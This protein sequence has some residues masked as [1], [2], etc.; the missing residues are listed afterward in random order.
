MYTSL[1]FYNKTIK[2]IFFLVLFII[3]SCEY[4]I[5]ISYHINEKYS[6]IVD[7][8]K[9]EYSKKD[10]ITNEHFPDI[11]QKEIYNDIEKQNIENKSYNNE[12]NIEQGEKPCR[13]FKETRSILYNQTVSNVSFSPNGEL[14]A[15]LING[16]VMVWD[17]ARQL[18][19]HEI[20]KENKFFYEFVFLD[21]ESILL[22]EISNRADYFLYKANLLIQEIREIQ[23]VKS[24][25]K[26][27]RINSNSQKSL[28]AIGF[29]TVGST[30]EDKFVIWNTKTEKIIFIQNNLR[31]SLHHIAFDNVGNNIAYH[32][33]SDFFRVLNLNN[34]QEKKFYY[35]QYD[36]VGGITSI[37][38]NLDGSVM[39]SSTSKGL[40]T[41]WDVNHGTILR[42]L[43]PGGKSIPAT[44]CNFE[45]ID[46]CKEINLLFC[47][48]M[49][50]WDPNIAQGHISAVTSLVFNSDS[51]LLYSASYDQTIRIWDIKTGTL[52]QTLEGHTDRVTSLSIHP[53]GKLLLSG[54]DD[55]TVR[56]W[57]CDK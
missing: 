22:A 46:Q 2:I 34:Y 32:S 15:I 11:I 52:L 30:P 43:G 29:Q 1:H 28:A 54:S 19:L 35:D 36:D 49:K 12:Q 55:K 48:R 25:I 6:F 38:L 20:K 13:Y 31:Y 21:N 40:I 57:K 10:T 24:P 26:F 7:A 51:T 27:V 16:K 8:N 37:L 47:F 41:L 18:Y 33:N 53:N 14:F 4:N 39:A 50:C 56:L 9:Q 42:E 44:Y 17:T 5:K 3:F 23:L 45:Y